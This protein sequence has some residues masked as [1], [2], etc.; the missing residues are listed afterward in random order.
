MPSR[1]VRTIF[2]GGSPRCL[3]E[4]RKF[5]MLSLDEEL[6]VGQHQRG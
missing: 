4:I 2:E 5:P 3:Q 6:A 1:T